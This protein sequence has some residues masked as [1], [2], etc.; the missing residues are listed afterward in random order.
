MGG[1]RWKKQTQNRLEPFVP[2]LLGTLDSDAWRA[3]SHGAKT[4]YICLKRR[5]FPKN[6]NNGYM[7]LSQRDA[8]EEM[9]S[10][11]NQIARWFRELQHYGFIV[12]TK[13]GCLGVEG[14]GKAPHWRLTELGYQKDPPTREFKRWEGTKFKNVK[15]GPRVGKKTATRAGNQARS[16]RK[17]KHTSVP[18]NHQSVSRSVPK[19]PHIQ[20]PDGAQENGHITRLPYQRRRV[21]LIEPID[22][23]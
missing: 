14:R 21:R 22:P 1:D 6:H 12:Q 3:M 5:Y 9:R 17:N 16:V 13:P 10:H 20:T 2:M 8:A 19:S 23:P 15:S 7:F 4:L 11:H 18:G